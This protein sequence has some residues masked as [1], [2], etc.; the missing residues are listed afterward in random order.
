[1]DLERGIIKALFYDYPIGR[2]IKILEGELDKSKQLD[3]VPE[4]L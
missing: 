2:L 4:I 1:M 3:F